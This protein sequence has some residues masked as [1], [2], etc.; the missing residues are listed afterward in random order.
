MLQIGLCTKTAHA[1]ITQ[2]TR[3]KGLGVEGELHILSTF[4]IFSLELYVDNYF[5]ETEQTKKSTILVTILC[6]LGYVLW[7][8]DKN[9]E[10]ICFD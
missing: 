2:P 1:Y 7:I 5:G 3:E 8:N 4:E 9:L 6:I 10:E